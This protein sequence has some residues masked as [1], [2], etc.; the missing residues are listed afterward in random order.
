MIRRTA[1]RHLRAVARRQPVVTLTGPRQS[2]KTTLCRAVFRGKP[3]VSLEAPDVREYAERD[4]RGFLAQYEGGAVF[5]E[6]QRVPGLLSYLQ[7]MVDEDPR[8]G[9]FVLSGSQNLAMQRAVSQSLAGRTALVSLLPLGYEELERFEGHPTDLF[10]TLLTG[11][12]P[13]I[14]DRGVRAAEWLADYVATYVERD[15]RLLLGVSDL[16]AFQRFLRLTAGRAGQI[17]NFSALAADAGISHNTAS[18]WLGVL[19]ASYLVARLPAYH[20]NLGKR[21]VKAPKLCFL[22]SGLLAWLLGI[23]DPDQLRNHPL[24]GAVFESWVASE[25]LKARAHHGRAPEVT[26][27][28]DRHGTEIDAVVETE[29]DVVLVEAKSGET[30]AGDF[31]GALARVAPLV[32]AAAKPR[33]VLPL[34]VYGGASPQTRA[35]AR[36]VPWSR[37]TSIDWVRG[38]A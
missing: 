12:Y 28:R 29:T 35:D 7:G 2:G 25:I 36:V 38:R 22:D 5:D 26:H 34:I 20:R 19:E 9:R 15:V 33:S 4:P 3:Y 14:H 10:S 31:F 16:G 18:A 17:V 24:R 30:V 8:P 23:R 27:Y 11:G 1:E 32:Q 13:A 6:V 21:L 37:I